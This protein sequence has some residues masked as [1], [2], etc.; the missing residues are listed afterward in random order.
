VRYQIA[1]CDQSKINGDNKMKKLFFHF[2]LAG[3]I[4]SFLSCGEDNPVPTL[5]G[6]SPS[7]SVSRLPGFVL[8]VTG[9]NFVQGAKIIFNGSEK[10]TTYVSGT[11]LTC[12][13]ST[14]D[15][16]T[17]AISDDINMIQEKNLGDSAVNVTVTN[18]SPGG[19]QSG[20]LQFLI[21]SNH[22]FAASNNLLQT[23][24][25]SVGVKIA[26]DPAG[27]IN[28][29]WL[30]YQPDPFNTEIYLIRSTDSG[31]NWGSVINVSQTS[32]IS[33]NPDVAVDVSNNISV[34][35]QEWIPDTTQYDIYFRRSI[36]GGSNW[37]PSINISKSP[38]E[39]SNPSI[40]IDSSGNIYAAW[41]ERIYKSGIDKYEIHNSRSIDN[42]ATWSDPV[43][44]SEI[45]CESPPKLAVSNLGILAIV[46]RSGGCTDKGEIYF[47]LSADQGT[48]WTTPV[49][50]SNTS[51][52]STLPDITFDYTANIYIVWKDEVSKNAEIMAV[53]SSDYG[54]TWTAP[55]NISNTTGFSRSPSLKADLIGNVNVVWMDQTPG[56]Y[57][58]Y[59]SRSTD[60]G[61]T[62]SQAV[63]A[64]NTTGDSQ[65]PKLGLNSMGYLFIAW[66]DKTLGNPDVYFSRSRISGID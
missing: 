55:F 13:I 60:G 66:I 27:N 53:K 4:L 10:D 26:V 5:T 38:W 61:T 40:A 44:I 50:I 41:L 48:L 36:T 23:S 54:A 39:S 14:A 6:L 3:I 12:N 19:G 8:H 33:L 20:S 58:V 51:T 9:S 21:L 1:Y 22:T 24:Q 46:W 11:E 43:I 7:Y 29:V 32:D 62:W 42:G 65:N 59:F 47:S 64:S 52:E 30:E 16:A 17:L 25:D 2:F 49:N 37:G 34:A 31:I 56:N 28:I 35:W 57:E 15:T 45:F 63:N 18:P